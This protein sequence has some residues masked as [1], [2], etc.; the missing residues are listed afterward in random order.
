MAR[1]TKT[2][3]GVHI[4]HDVGLLGQSHQQD[5]AAQVAAGVQIAGMAVLGPHPQGERYGDREGGGER[6]LVTHRHYMILNT[7]RCLAVSRR[8]YLVMPRPI[9]FASSALAACRG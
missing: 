4:A 2:R 3:G 9:I 8:Q 7:T 6:E 1:S 5:R